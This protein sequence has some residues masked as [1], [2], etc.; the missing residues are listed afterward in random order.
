MLAPLQF[1]ILNLRF[2]YLRTYRLKYTEVE[3]GK[4][5]S[6]ALTKYHSMK[7]YPLLNSASHHED[8]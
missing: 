7:R 6:L 2:S 4:I 5:M 3:E 1:R 8:V